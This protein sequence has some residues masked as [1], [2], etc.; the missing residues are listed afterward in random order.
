MRRC[1]SMKLHLVSSIVCLCLLTGGNAF[2]KQASSPGHSTPAAVVVD[3]QEK[4]VGQFF[5]NRYVLVNVNGVNVLLSVD[6]TG[7]VRSGVVL[8]FESTD[9]TGIPYLT[10]DTPPD[11]VVSR[12]FDLSAGL[13]NNTLY[14]P[15]FTTAQTRTFF[16]RQFTDGNTGTVFCS[17][18]GGQSALSATYLMFDLSSLGFT[19]P[20]S[21]Q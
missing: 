2:A 17:S 4:V 10:M 1:D 3:S 9:C 12:D 20:F 11:L 5:P 16:S 6:T 21:V 19:P 18:L 15:D 7:F 14:Y 8:Y 13:V